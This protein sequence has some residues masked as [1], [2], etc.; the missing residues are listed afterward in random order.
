MAGF[1][2]VAVGRFASPAGLRVRKTL[3]GEWTRSSRSIMDLVRNLKSESVARLNPTQAHVVQPT[4][5]I[6]DAVKIMRE[7]KVGCVLVCEQRRI[8]GIFTERDLLRRVLG[9]GRPL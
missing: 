5:P 1:G 4:Q 7:R 6:A 3:F 8:I 2:S 9:E